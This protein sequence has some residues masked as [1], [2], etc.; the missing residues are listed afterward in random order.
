MTVR[1]PKDAANDVRQKDAGWRISYTAP[2]NEVRV[3]RDTSEGATV[4]SSFN[5]AMATALA[6]ADV[7]YPGIDTE[8]SDV[9][10]EMRGRLK[11]TQSAQS[12][13]GSPIAELDAA[14]Y[15]RLGRQ[16]HRVLRQ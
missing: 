15:N 14:L 16:Q 5:F 2:I 13:T 10:Y 8:S 6:D 12:V 11:F 1:F 9:F 4:I 7:I 3:T